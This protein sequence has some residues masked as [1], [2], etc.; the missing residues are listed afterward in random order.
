MNPDFLKIYSEARDQK[1]TDETLNIIQETIEDYPYFSLGH[2]LLAKAGEQQN[3]NGTGKELLTAAAYSANRG[4]LKKY[5]LGNGQAKS[6]TEEVKVAPVEVEEK[7]EKVQETT[8]LKE[9]VE[10]TPAAEEQKTATPKPISNASSR[11]SI[12]WG[13]NTRIRIRVRQN[14]QQVEKIRG[15]LDSFKAK[16]ADKADTEKIQIHLF[17]KMTG[18]SKSPPFPVLKKR[19]R[20]QW[21]LK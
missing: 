15:E 10:T 4:L 7:A 11:A 14:I 6:T 1:L 18:R 19:K 16:Y 21:N 2:T 13:M 20:F 12:D 17:P 8:D 9:T 5:I 3:G